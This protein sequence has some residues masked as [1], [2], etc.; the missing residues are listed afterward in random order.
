M[1]S[2]WNRFSANNQIWTRSDDTH[3][4]TLLLMAPNDETF[5]QSLCHVS[6]NSQNFLWFATKVTFWRRRQEMNSLPTERYSDDARSEV[7][8]RFH[9]FLL[10]E[11]FHRFMKQVQRAL[12]QWK[13]TLFVANQVQTDAGHDSFPALAIVCSLQPPVDYSSKWEA[14]TKDSWPMQVLALNISVVT[15]NHKMLQ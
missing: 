7:I 10:S 3:S 5:W 2:F 9:W 6:I 8:V 4:I 12:N 13:Q 1:A 11:L 14:G 15:Q